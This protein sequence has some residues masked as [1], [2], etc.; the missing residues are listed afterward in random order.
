MAREKPE[1]R[2][3]L[4]YLIDDKKYP[5]TMTKG[6]AAKAIGVSR[7]HLDKII[8][9]GRIKV[10]DGKVPIGSIASYLCG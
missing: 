8:A 5:P 3:M 4:C 6:Q 7:G 10:Q 2:N 9:R 1:F